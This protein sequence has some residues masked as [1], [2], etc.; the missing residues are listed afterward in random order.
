MY[1][2]ALGHHMAY[3]YSISGISFG[4]LMILMMFSAFTYKAKLF[5][6]IGWAQV[7]NGC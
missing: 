2:I 7:K 3:S 5:P 6:V 4:K 1:E